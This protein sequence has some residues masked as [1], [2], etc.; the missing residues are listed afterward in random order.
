MKESTPAVLIR[1]FH[2]WSGFALILLVAAKLISGF[3]LAGAIGFPGEAAAN[4]M[5]FARWVDVP[6][7][8]FF[9]F[10]AAYGIL[11]AIMARGIQ[12]KVRAFTAATAAALLIFAAYLLFVL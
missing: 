10:H 12:K 8:F 1:H 9:V 11:K 4:R 6:L 3:R 5:H 2:R 7:V